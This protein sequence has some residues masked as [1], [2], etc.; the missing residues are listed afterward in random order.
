MAK[1]A[2]GR[3][4]A[5]RR[6]GAK[7]PAT[8]RSA[9]PAAKARAKVAARRRAEAAASAGPAT[10]P[11]I[12][13]WNELM[14]TDVPAAKAFYGALF[15]WGAADSPMPGIGTYTRFLRG[16]D[17]AAG[18]MKHPHAGAP[19]AWLAYV[20]VASVD[21]TASKVAG[22]GGR[23]VVPPMDIPNMG[24]FA[25]ATDPQGAEFAMFQSLV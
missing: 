20:Q 15:G 17:S 3:G 13:C 12:F 10:G 19:P 8:K 1:K 18:L 6:G 16:K 14:T 23:L 9:R 5:R 2:K 24:R 25:I 11:G 21:E 7:R 4:A 22:L